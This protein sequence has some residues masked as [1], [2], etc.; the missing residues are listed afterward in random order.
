MPGCQDARLRIIFNLT[1]N[2]AKEIRNIEEVREVCEK[3]AK[4]ATKQS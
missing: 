4:K 2:E 1:L 3:R